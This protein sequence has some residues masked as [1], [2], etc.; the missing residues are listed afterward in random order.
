[1]TIQLSRKTIRQ[2]FP[3][4]MQVILNHDTIGN[5]LVYVRKEDDIRKT[6]HYWSQ[7][8]TSICINMC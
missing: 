7:L 5:P 1:M 8:S 4:D 2:N 3:R 6:I